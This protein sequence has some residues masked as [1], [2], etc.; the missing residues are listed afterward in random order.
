M[1]DQTIVNLVS[2]VGFEKWWR[3]R[4]KKY[5]FKEFFK[6]KEKKEKFQKV[7][8]WCLLVIWENRM[9]HIEFFVKNL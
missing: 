1:E 5:S 6:S 4:R 2:M 7:R 8:T 3:I 9:N